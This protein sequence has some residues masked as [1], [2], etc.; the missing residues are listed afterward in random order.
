MAELQISAYGWHPRD[1][2]MPL[3]TF[4]ENGGKRAYEVAH[5][6]WGKDDVALNWAAVS[7]LTKVGNYWHMLPEA[8]QARKAIWDAVNPHT[9][10]RRIDEAFPAEIRAT[11]K[12]QEMFIRFINSSHPHP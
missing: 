9:G 10:R 11:T 7:A 3:W 8:S 1:Y 6:R 4:L 5:R 2:Q 12:E